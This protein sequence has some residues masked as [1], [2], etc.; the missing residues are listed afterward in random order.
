M[1]N[2][3]RRGS[4]NDPITLGD[5]TNLLRET[6]ERLKNWFK[7]EMSF[8]KEKVTKLESSLSMAQNECVR[9]DTELTKMKETIISQQLQIESNESKLRANNLIFHNIAED[10]I[11]TGAECLSNDKEKLHFVIHTAKIDVTRDDILSA[12]R[13]GKRQNERTRPLKVTFKDS[14]VKYNF[15]NKRR[16]VAANVELAKVFHKKIFINTDSSFLI[17][18]EEFRLRQKLKKIKNDDPATVS[19]IRSGSLHSNGQIIDKID[20]RNQL[21]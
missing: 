2:T 13:L 19:F 17:Q 14:N 5:I 6:E 16:E 4:I 21:F 3:R 9:L 1:A 11:S 8:L 12:Q 7:D 18:K 10:S 20:I 15:L